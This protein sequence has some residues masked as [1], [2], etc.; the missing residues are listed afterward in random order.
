MEKPRA[1]FLKILQLKGARLLDK[2]PLAQDGVGAVP[3]VGTRGKLLK[4]FASCQSS[5]VGSRP[6]SITSCM[7]W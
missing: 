1:P 7:M 5:L 4:D 6:S 2:F 3:L